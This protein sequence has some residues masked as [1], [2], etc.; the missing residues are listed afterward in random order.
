V[1]VTL[2]NF[3]SGEARIAGEL[4]LIDVSRLGDSI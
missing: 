4:S 3:A 1:G 2:S